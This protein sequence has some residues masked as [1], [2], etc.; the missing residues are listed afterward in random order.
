MSTG[1]E[2]WWLLL[3]AVGTVNIVAWAATAALLRRR[4]GSESYAAARLQL[5]LSAVYVFGCAFRSVLPVFDI[6]RIVLFN[7][8][9]SSVL[10]GRTVATCAELCFVAQ[11][12]LMLRLL[13]ELTGKPVVRRISFVILPLIGLAELCSWYA[14]LTTSNLGHVVE[15]SLWGI[16]AGLMV[17]SML[18]TLPRYQGRLRPLLLI[19]C[20]A[21]SAYVG[22]MF[23][24]DVPRYFT[25]WLS[26]QAHGHQDLTILQGMLDVARHRVVSYRWDIWRGEVTWMSLYFSVAVWLSIS[27]IHAAAREARTRLAQPLRVGR[28]PAAVRIQP[29]G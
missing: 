4:Y 1:V 7:S 15:E 5:L 6:P 13:A 23:S 20:L 12:A 10:V 18:A 21:G 8:W 26:D 28:L 24:V 3:C 11:W 2:A 27:L 25:R 22:Y 19:A 16:A 17:V 29:Q 9:L 14:V